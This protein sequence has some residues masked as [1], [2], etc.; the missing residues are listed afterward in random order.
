MY[1][2]FIYNNI[3]C[4]WYPRYHLQCLYVKGFAL[5]FEIYITRYWEQDAFYYSYAK[6]KDTR[7]E[8]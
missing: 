6:F 4:L 7:Q 3:S 8:A 1:L 5:V 2:L